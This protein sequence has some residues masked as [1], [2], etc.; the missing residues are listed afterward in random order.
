MHKSAKISKKMQNFAKMCKF[1][2]KCSKL[3]KKIACK[4]EKLAQLEKISTKGVTSVTIFF[5]L[6]F[7]M[8]MNCYENMKLYH[9]FSFLDTL[10]C[11]SVPFSIFFHYQYIFQ[12]VL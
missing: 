8:I 4:T 1:L 11:L 5:H 6:C 7:L 9:I 2:Q 10:L 3:C 12:K